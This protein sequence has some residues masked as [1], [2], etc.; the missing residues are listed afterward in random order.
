[1]QINNAAKVGG[2][3]V[4]VCVFC[5]CSFSSFVFCFWFVCMVGWFFPFRKSSYQD[6]LELIMKGKYAC[7][8]KAIQL[9]F[10]DREVFFVLCCVFFFFFFLTS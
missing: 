10:L 9:G 3:Q 7:C 6:N 1:M 5:C 4:F 8:L 2:V